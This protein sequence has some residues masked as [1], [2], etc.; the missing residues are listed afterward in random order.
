MKRRINKNGGVTLPKLVR[1]EAG[2]HP[3]M[4]VDIVATA[5]GNVA[6]QSVHRCC[7]LCGSPEDVLEIGNVDI[8]RNCAQKLR[9]VL[10]EQK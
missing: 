5:Q 3:G 8:C 1:V 2:L 9:E 10:D 6:V 7:L 4:A